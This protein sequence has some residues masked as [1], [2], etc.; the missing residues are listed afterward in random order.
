M[1]GK[2]HIINSLALASIPLAF[3][4]KVDTEYILI[5]LLIGLGSILPDIDEP[6]SMIGR[7]MKFLSYPINIF[8]GHRTITHNLVLFAISGIFCYLNDYTFLLALNIGI[9]LHIL[10]DSITYQGITNGL[11]PF[12][13]LNYN[14]VLLPRI[15]RFKVGG[16]TEYLILILSGIFLLI[17]LFIQLGI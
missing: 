4:T 8:F 11:F 10:Q 3:E 9:L 16:L 7:K 1:L 2:T 17:V 5:L 14:F 12:Q 13:R 15:L 6:S